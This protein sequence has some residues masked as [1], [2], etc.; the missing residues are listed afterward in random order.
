[1]PSLLLL[2]LSVGTAS[3]QPAAPPRQWQPALLEIDAMVAGELAK[4]GVGSVTIGIVSGPQ[5]VWT[6]SYGMA[7][8]AAKRPA[9][10]ESVYRIG[11]ITKQFTA[12]MLLQL[13]EQGKV[14][15]SDPVVKYVPEFQPAALHPGMPV[16]TLVQLATMTSGVAR[17]PS[18]PA[19]HSSGP[20][21][22]WQ[23]KV[24]LSLPF[25]KYAHEPDTRYLYSNIGY[26]TLGVALAR[27]AGQPFTA[28]VEQRIAAPLGMTRTAFDASD[29]MRPHLTRAYEIE[30]DGKVDGEAS[31]RE[32]AGRGYRVPNGGLFST[33]DD[34]ARFVS[35]ELGFGPEGILKKETQEANYA[36]LNVADGDLSSGYGVGFMATRRGTLVV[37]GH[38]GSTAGYR[39]AANFHRRSKTGV[40]VL[41]S[42]AGGKVNVNEV[43]LR[44]LAKLAALQEPPAT[45]GQP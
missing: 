45:G 11:S 35:W 13:V 12:L 22:G 41:A 1:M 20:V 25:V 37:L 29:A 28:W 27:A 21:S 34:L 24:F 43:A 23:E 33:V 5:L 26:A 30:R 40:I 38:G 18:G 16:P 15:L 19:D 8:N 9:T 7:D 39:A 10:R 2:L 36:N 4:D 42:V 44:T 14:R 6:K 3:A 17:E 31:V 32:H